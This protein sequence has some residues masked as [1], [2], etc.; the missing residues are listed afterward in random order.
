MSTTATGRQRFPV[1]RVTL[2]LI[3]IAAIA[4]MV[5][6]WQQ[7]ATIAIPDP[8]LRAALHEVLRQP[9]DRP[10]RKGDLA[11]VTYL[12]LTHKTQIRDLTGL[13]AA[14]SLEVLKLR[15]TGAAAAPLESQLAGLRARGIRVEVEVVSDT[16]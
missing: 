6:L 7:Q 3:L 13:E 2:L 15:V 9:V 11:R 16:P 5:P 8:V 4:F 12:D 1:P 10:F 14:V